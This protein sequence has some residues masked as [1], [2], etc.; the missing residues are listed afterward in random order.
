MWFA[1]PFGAGCLLCQYLLPD[2]WRMWAAAA[3]LALAVLFRKADKIAVT[4]AVGLAVGVLWFSGYAAL[5][6]APAEAL[7]GTEG[8]VGLEV[9]DYPV[10][11]GYGIRCT[12]RVPGLRGK[13]VYYGNASLRT[14]EPGDWVTGEVKC[15]SAQTLGGSES[16]YYASQGVFLRLYGRGTALVAAPEGG[17]WR[18]LPARL[19]RWLREAAGRLYTPQA[20][21]L[22]TA[23]LTGDR[24]DLDEQGLCDLTESGLLHI[25]AV[26]GLHCGFLIAMLSA[27]LFRRQRLTAALG[28]PVLLFYVV[29]AGA[30]PPAVRSCVMVG[31][32]L[33]APLAGRE[34]DPPTSLSAALLLMLL[35]NPFA[36]ASVS[37]QLSFASVTGLIVAAP[38]IQAG[39]DSL[40]P[41]K[42]KGFT[43]FLWRFFSGM[44]AA[45]LGVM[46]L[47]APLSAAYFEAL[48]LVG[49]LANLLALWMAPALFCCGLALTALCGLFPALAPLAAAPEWM[50][51]YVLWVAGRLAKLPGHCVYFTGGAAVMWLLLVYTLLALC[52]LSRGGRRQWATALAL[53]AAC[54]AAAKALPRAVVRSDALTAVAVDV[55]QGAA[56]LLHSGQQT[57][58]VDCGCLGAPRQAG[59]A[60]ATAMDAY[61]W[62]RLD[63]VILTHYHEDHAGGLAALLARVDVDA[64]L[65]PQLEHSAGQSALQRET[66]ALAGRYGVAASYVER[67]TRATVG[68]A[69][70]TV[71]PPVAEGGVNEE[72]LTILCTCGDFDLL[73]TGDM[74]AAAERALVEAYELPDIEVLVAGH[75]GSKYSSS[76]ELL[77]AV[78][79]EAGIISVGENSFGHPA[80]EAMG[81]MAGFGMDLYRTDWQGN[82]LIRVRGN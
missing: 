76:E 8:V 58:L 53:S 63:C 52:A 69:A 13:A 61:G 23:M 68:G 49:P 16:Q 42:P 7:A 55:G 73:M 32:F 9:L 35:G 50:A 26:S 34:N 38:K 64:L 25:T 27:L 46:L 14:L 60:V 71:Y 75:H 30:T 72:G 48:P 6:L 82:I 29:M 57:V 33:L 66:L 70:L 10:E 36:A 74:N 67:P 15:Y 59:E 3:A 20:A 44:L 19:N 24:D 21:G 40:L 45:S 2:G 62:D 11:T 78:R 18:Y 56:T 39:L 28:Y 80:G 51:R 79:P 17:G 81:R 1:L 37:L 47:T 31:F 4:A 5:Y 41:R 77:A 43:G 12:V 54:L 22:L 65:L